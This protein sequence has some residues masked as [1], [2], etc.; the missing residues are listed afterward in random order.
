MELPLYHRPN[1]ESIG[2]FVWNN[3]WAFL[4]KAG[5]IILLVAVVVWMLSSYPGA[6]VE[7]S[8]LARFGRSLSPLGELMGMDWRLLTALLSSFIAKENAIATLGILYGAAEGGRGLA[9]TLAASIPPASALAFLI[10]TMLFIPCAATVAVMRQE[11]RSWRWTLF[12]V[13]L[14]LLIALGAGVIA[15]QGARVLGVGG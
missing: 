3:T 15:Y 8:Y 10:V 9:E 5:S 13:S 2:Y 4:R 11:L 1:L 14:L 6:D 7:Q 12:G